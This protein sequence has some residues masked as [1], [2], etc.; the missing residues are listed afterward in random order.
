M[1]I[2]PLSSVDLLQTTIRTYHTQLLQPRNVPPPVNP[3]L[4]L[5]PYC[6]E[7]P[8]LPEHARNVLSDLFR[9]FH[10]LAMAATT[11]EGHHEIRK[12][13]NNDPASDVADRVIAFWL[14]EFLVE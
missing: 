9:N 5:L 14:Q 1:P 3:T 7:R 12:W 10:E 4:E 2:I 13:L 6:A 11:S 8:P